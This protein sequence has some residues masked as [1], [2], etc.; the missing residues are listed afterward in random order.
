MEWDNLGVC[1]NGSGRGGRR[2][3]AERGG[4]GRERRERGE[5]GRG[6]GVSQVCCVVRV[7]SSARGEGLCLS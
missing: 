3:E 7:A 4:R 6:K 2:E 5:G 1:S